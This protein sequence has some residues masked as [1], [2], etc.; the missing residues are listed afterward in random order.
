M[1]LF[2]KGK[3]N[4]QEQK[5]VEPQDVATDSLPKCA[6]A[7]VI[8]D[9]CCVLADYNHFAGCACIPVALEK[10]TS[11]GCHPSVQIPN[12][13]EVYKYLNSFRNLPVEFRKLPLSRTVMEYTLAQEYTI[14]DKRT[15]KKRNFPGCTLWLLPTG[16]MIADNDW[17]SYMTPEI[18][19][20]IAKRARTCKALSKQLLDMRN[21]QTVR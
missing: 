7:H 5:N 21:A 4:R 18:R 20:D 8:A 19:N 15:K 6:T 1:G 11:G 13:V 2:R 14:T 9:P 17:L 16:Y 10:V 3:I 12:N